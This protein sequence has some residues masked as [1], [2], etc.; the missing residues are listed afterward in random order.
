MTSYW[1]WWPTVTA[2][3]T[4]V[5]IVVDITIHDKYFAIDCFTPD[6]GGFDLVLSVHWLC[7][8]GPIVWDFDALL[9][10]FLYND[11]S[12]HWIG[13]G[14]RGVTARAVVDQRAILEELL[15]S[16]GDIFEAPH[17]LLPNCR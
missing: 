5:C 1:S 6:L 13:M 17:E 7:S 15:L 16:Y 9:M 3:T 12:H 14:S 8:L 11:R 4:Q 2:C 10:A